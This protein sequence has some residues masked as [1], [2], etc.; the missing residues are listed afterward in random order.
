MLRTSLSPKFQHSDL[1][2]DIVI[3]LKINVLYH[4]KHGDAVALTSE[5]AVGMPVGYPV[6]TPAFAFSFSFCTVTWF[7][8]LV[9]I[10]P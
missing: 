6:P 8:L 9:Q 10:G 5:F 4:V 1:I 7:L 2:Y 3:H